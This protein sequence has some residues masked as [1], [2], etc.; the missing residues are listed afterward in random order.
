MRVKMSFESKSVIHNYT[1]A[2]CFYSSGV[3]HALICP[4]TRPTVQKWV[5]LVNF[6]REPAIST[7]INHLLA[8]GVCKKR[9]PIKIKI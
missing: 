1:T 2:E 9:P 5:C 6:T 4:F 3:L 8:V 7:V